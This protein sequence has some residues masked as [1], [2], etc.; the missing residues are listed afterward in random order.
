MADIK[1][2]Q[3]KAWQPRSVFSKHQIVTW[4]FRCETC[5]AQN[6]AESH[7]RTSGEQRGSS[8]V[9]W[10]SR[11]GTPRGYA[12]TEV[13]YSLGGS[14]LAA[15]LA[16]AIVKVAYNANAAFHRE[17]A[18]VSN[19]LCMKTLRC[20]VGSGVFPAANGLVMA[21]AANKPDDEKVF[22][23]IISADGWP[24]WSWVFMG[25]PHAS[26]PV[27]EYDER[28]PKRA[29]ANLYKK[30]DM[31]GKDVPDNFRLRATERQKNPFRG[32]GA[33]KRI[34]AFAETRPSEVRL[35]KKTGLTM[36][37]WLERR[38]RRKD[39]AG[40]AV[41][42]RRYVFGSADGAVSPPPP[43]GSALRR[44]LRQR[45][46]KRGGRAAYPVLLTREAS[47]VAFAQALAIARGVWK[48]LSA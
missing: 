13:R 8:I 26:L 10:G 39:L 25:V 32:I 3:C 21:L 19:R 20:Q 45:E 29:D 28:W 44:L 43:V 4:Q 34:A 48:D 18:F 14:V 12:T 30:I 5:C 46:K 1:C 16:I 35:Q 41:I 24:S 2:S 7:K 6:L 40:H 38:H 11:A 37:D 23:G 33:L 9:R 36:L 27:L 31:G 22:S 15:P 42:F 17:G 47:P